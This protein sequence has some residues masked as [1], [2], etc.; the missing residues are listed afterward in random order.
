MK[1]S[2]IPKWLTITDNLDNNSFGPGSAT[3]TQ[4]EV[5]S[6]LVLT[7]TYQGRGH[8]T[9]TLTVTASNVTPGEG[10][11]SSPVPITI[12]DPPAPSA[13]HNLA[14]DKRVALLNQ[15]SAGFGASGFSGEH[16]QLADSSLASAERFLV[17][18]VTQPQQ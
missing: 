1:I 11:I 6:G 3:L 12:V 2:G 13:D 8:P 4:A 17:Q 18:P 9:A 15:Y 5:N 14:L 16:V 7:S 10:A